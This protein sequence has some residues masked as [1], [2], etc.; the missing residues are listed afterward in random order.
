MTN[1]LAMQ[2]VRALRGYGA[3]GMARCPAHRDR[4]PSLAIPERDGRVLVHCHAG[5]NQ[6]F[7]VAALYRL[8]LWPTQV[9]VNPSRDAAIAGPC[10][11]ATNVVETSKRERA[12]QV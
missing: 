12:L 10:R 1:T 4:I 2:I 9:C 8:G 6:K 11:Y 3:S 5:C 7:V